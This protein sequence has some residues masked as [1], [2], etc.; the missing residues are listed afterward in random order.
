MLVM[1]YPAPLG[2]SLRYVGLALAFEALEPR[3]LGPHIDI[4]ERHTYWYLQATPALVQ[5]IAHA[6]KALHRGEL[7]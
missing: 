5:Q 3:S 1:A 6:G 7:S 2:L 4:F